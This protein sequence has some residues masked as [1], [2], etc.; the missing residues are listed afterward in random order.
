MTDTTDCDPLW[1]TC[2]T[3]TSPDITSPETSSA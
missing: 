3:T 1:E 2:D